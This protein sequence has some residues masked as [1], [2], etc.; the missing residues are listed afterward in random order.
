MW[1]IWLIIA[2]IFFVGEIFTVGFLLFWFGIGAL[3]AL[4]TSLITSNVIIQT[5]VFLISSVI[6]LF[7]TKPLVNKFLNTGK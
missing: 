4:I 1:Q 2:G 5:V 6:L 7:A 3:I